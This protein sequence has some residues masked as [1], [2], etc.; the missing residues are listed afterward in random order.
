MASSTLRMDERMRERLTLLTSV[1]R[2][3]LRAAFLAD[4]VLAMS[5]SVYLILSCQFAIRA[6]PATL[7]HCRCKTERT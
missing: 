5:L 4:V 2:A 7:R 6:R 1:F 3:I